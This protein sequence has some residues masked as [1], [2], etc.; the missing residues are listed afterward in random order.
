M[1][2]ISFHVWTDLV[3]HSMQ[4]SNGSQ[5]G[6]GFFYLWIIEGFTN[7]LLSQYQ[8]PYLKFDGS[9]APDWTRPGCGLLTAAGGP[10]LAEIPVIWLMIFFVR[11][12]VIK[13]KF[14]GFPTWTKH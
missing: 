9:L 2:S 10:A 6:L 11:P 4:A 8:K 5:D 12:D 1:L 7:L 14:R 3:F 13:I